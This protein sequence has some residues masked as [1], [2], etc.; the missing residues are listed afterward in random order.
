MSDP[1]LA[2]Q[3]ALYERL[4]E[5]LDC[6]VFD[7]VPDKQP[8]PYVTLDREFSSNTSPITGKRRENRLFYLSVWSNYPGQAEVKQI[9][10]NI[11]A[12]LNEKPLPLETGRAVSVRVTRCETIREPDNRTFMGAVTL[13]IITQ[14]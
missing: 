12:A 1:T 8:Y 6:P 5:A 7:A 9:M 10:I 14:H 3:K 11:A 13:R 4:T 2:L